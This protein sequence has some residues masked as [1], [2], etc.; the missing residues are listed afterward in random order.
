[1]CRSGRSLKRSCSSHHFGAENKCKSVVRILDWFH[2]GK[3]FKNTE[4]VISENHKDQF[5]RAKW[6]LWHGDA[7]KALL[8][9]NSIKNDLTEGIIKL[10]SLITYIN[11]NKKHIVNYQQRKAADLSFTSNVAETHVNNV[12]NSRQ[13]N[14]GRMQWSR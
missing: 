4:S 6:C 13:K 9:L 10:D 5:D 11:N 8:K 7:K 14:D 3:K 2:I 12:I 1:M